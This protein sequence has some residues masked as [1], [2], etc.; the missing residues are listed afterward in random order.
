MPERRR[1]LIVA[2]DAYTDPRL[3]RLSAPVND[4][5]ALAGL[6]SD[7]DVGG[8][9]QVKLLLNKSSAVT[10]SALERFY[11][12]AEHTD[13][14]LLY[15][16]GHGLK[17]DYGKFFL[18]ARNTRVDQL[19]S[20]SIPDML[21]KQMM[22]ES[23]AARQVLIL[24]CCF[25]GAFASKLAKGDAA[26]AQERFSGAGKVVLT[27]SNA[28]Q[29]ALDADTSAAGMALS[30]FTGAVVQGLSSGDADVDRDGHVSA[31]DLFQ[32][33]CDSLRKL[34]S[35]QKPTISSAGM[36]G[37]IFLARGRRRT[38]KA[39]MRDWIQPRSQGREGTLGPAL[40]AV[41]ALEASLARSGRK[42]TLSGRYMCQKAKLLEKRDPGSDPGTRMETL[43]RIIARSGCCPEDRWP[44]TSADGASYLAADPADSPELARIF[45]LPA[46]QTWKDLDAAAKPFRARVE[47]VTTVDSIR[48]HL[49]SG[50]GIFGAVRMGDNFRQPAP[51]G[52]IVAPPQDGPFQGTTCVAVVSFDGEQSRIWVCPSWGPGW[53]DGGFGWMT[54]Q[55]ARQ[56]FDT[57]RVMY[58][59]DVG[60]STTFSWGNP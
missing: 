14:A 5:N 46:G 28:M 59:V 23:H 50:H 10:L 4:A 38:L 6:L 16:S 47:D 39:S 57:S 56:V 45:A 31:D 26:G 36:E 53:N 19:Y 2:S 20:T 60:S 12:D 21:L 13:L 35:P 54:L 29:F 33:V 17:D 40:A 8:F 41:M 3:S 25:G 44:T 15:F 52:E 42:T 49:E 24:D 1:A 11:R 55:T 30:Q 58:A 48:Y 7:P 32:Y 18:A 43:A 9:T 27:A 34:K 37:K 22:D 51:D